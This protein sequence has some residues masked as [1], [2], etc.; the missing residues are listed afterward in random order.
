MLAVA[1]GVVLII[2]QAHILKLLVSFTAFTTFTITTTAAAANPF[3][4]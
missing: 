4:L 2:V 1:A 3:L